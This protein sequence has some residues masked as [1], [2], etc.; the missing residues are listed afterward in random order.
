MNGRLGG[1]SRAAKY[2]AET[3]TAWGEKAGAAT[4]A[5]YGYDYYRSISRLPKRP[6][7][8]DNIVN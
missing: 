1:L 2:D 8:P 6:K 4:I 7:Q 5:R 3:K